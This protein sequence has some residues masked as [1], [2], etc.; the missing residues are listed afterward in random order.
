QKLQ[1]QL[2]RRAELDTLKTACD[3]LAQQMIDAQQ[4]LE[5]VRQLQQRLVPLVAELNALR[6]SIG[7]AHERIN[8]VKFDEATV[9]DQEKRLAELVSASKAVATEVAERARQMQTLSEELARSTA[10]K[11]QML[12]ELAPGPSP[13]RDTVGQSQ[14]ADDQLA[15]AE[16]M[17]KQLEQRRTQVAFGEKKLAGVETRLADIKQI[18]DELDRNIQSIASREQLVNAVKA[19]VDAVHEI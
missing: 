2:A 6:T 16:K 4:K 17:F 7:T 15:R 5:S 14:A 13:H 18:A 10:I 19:E 8:G 1:E 9:A 12:A 3:G 11:D